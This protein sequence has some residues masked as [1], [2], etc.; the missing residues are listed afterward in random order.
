MLYETVTNDTMG[1]KFTSIFPVTRFRDIVTN[2]IYVTLIVSPVLKATGIVVALINPLMG[3]KLPEVIAQLAACATFGLFKLALDT[4]NN[5]EN[6][7]TTV[8]NV[9]NRR[10]ISTFLTY[11][12]LQYHF[13]EPSDRDSV[14]EYYRLGIVNFYHRD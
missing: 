13:L 11:F 2:P 14:Y 10:D 8:N 4:L 1:P 5:V 12:F 7:M 6:T 9:R 3:V